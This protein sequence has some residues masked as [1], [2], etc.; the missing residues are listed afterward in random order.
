MLMGNNTT[1][2]IGTTHWVPVQS[3]LTN[4]GN[5]IDELKM[6]PPTK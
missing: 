5:I 6:F 4:K 1:N 2:N 3:V